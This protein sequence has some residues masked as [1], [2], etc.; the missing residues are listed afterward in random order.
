M[1]PEEVI[2]GLECCQTQYNRTCDE[3]PYRI[4]K[5]HG[6]SVKTCDLRMRAD[7]LDM[8]NLLIKLAKV[9][10]SE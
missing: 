6:I 1:K 5:T 7:V 4:Y 3:C 2:K 8:L 9:D 10:W